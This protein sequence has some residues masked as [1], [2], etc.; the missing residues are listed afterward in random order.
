MNDENIKLIIFDAY[1]VCLSKGYPDT[2]EYLARKYRIDKKRILQIM[3]VKYMNL[4]AM[5]S[6]TQKEA[7]ARWPAPHSL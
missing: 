5:K 4:A 3:Y 6:V 1:G 7:W 2:A